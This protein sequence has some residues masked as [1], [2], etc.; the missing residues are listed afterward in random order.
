MHREVAK[1]PKTVKKAATVRKSAPVAPK[2]GRGRPFLNLDVE[3]IK[4]LAKIHCTIPEIASVM[5]CSVDTLDRNYAECIKDAQREGKASLRR[6]Q[7]KAAEDGNVTAMIWLGKQWL[8]QSDKQDVTHSGEIDTGGK[9][10]KA[11]TRMLEKAM[12][13]G[14]SEDEAIRSLRKLGVDVDLVLQT[15]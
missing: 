2:R 10:K 5:G 9:R 12:A 1:R 3:Q 11:V 13:G 6:C 8:G 4:A 7:V 15:D 14:I